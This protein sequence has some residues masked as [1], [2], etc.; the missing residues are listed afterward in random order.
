MTEQRSLAQKL[1][2]FAIFWL[3]GV[4]IVGAI[5]ASIRLVL[6]TH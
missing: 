6:M 2:W 5:A 1:V 4:G 3:V